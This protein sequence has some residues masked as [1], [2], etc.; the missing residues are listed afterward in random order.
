MADLPGRRSSSADLLHA[1]Y[2]SDSDYLRD[3][4]KRLDLILHIQVLRCAGQLPEHPLDPFRGIVLS[5]EAVLRLFLEPEPDLADPLEARTQSSKL[6]D[7]TEQLERLQPVIKQKRALS[8]L[9]D[10]PLA[11]PHI[12]ERFQ[13]TELEE[14]IVL[15]CL[16]P[17]L[18]VKYEK[19]YAYLQD[20]VTR[21]KPCAD[22]ILKLLDPSASDPVIARTIFHPHAGLMKHQLL[23][24]AESDASTNILTRSLHLDSQIIHFLLGHRD[25]DPRLEPAARFAKP[26]ADLVPLSDEQLTDRV[27]QLVATQLNANGM[28][29]QK[30]V[31]GLN[32][33]RGSGKQSLAEAVCRDLGIPL[34]VGDVQ[35]M[36]HHPLSFHDA[37]FLLCR[38]AY[39]HSAALCLYNMDSL[40]GQGDR[41]RLEIERFKQSSRS[42]PSLTFLLGAESRIPW[43]SDGEIS[44]IPVPFELPDLKA[45]HRLWKQLSERYCFEESID[46]EALAEKFRFTPGRIQDALRTARSYALW[47]NPE[48]W[49]IG[50][51]DLLQACHAQ[52]NHRLQLHADQLKPAGSWSDLILPADQIKRLKELIVQV[53]LR[54]IVHGEWGFGHKL[55]RGKGLNILLHGPPGTGKT[56]AAEVIAKELELDLYRIDLSQVVSKYIGETEKNLRQVFR[57]AQDSYAILLFDEADALFGKR[58]EVKDAHDRHAN[59]EIAYLLQQME[60]YDGVTILATNLYNN[61]DEAFIRRMQFSIE[62]PLPEQEYRMEIWKAMFPA[63]A[64]L[65]DDIDWEFLSRSFK[66][67][68]GHI[69]NAVLSAA[70]LA[71]ERSEAIGMKHLIRAVAREMD[72]TGKICSK[73]H[74]G[75]YYELLS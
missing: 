7:L 43:E 45:R 4:L 25:L 33:P 74:F 72:K 3:E 40:F 27:R 44:Y 57:E 21:H 56:T 62:F 30:L 29:M 66:I 39:L 69:K 14:Q 53:Q 5:E 32:G 60:E 34:I 65:A 20:D 64:P 12:A 9:Q 22:L 17:E 24:F 11:L 42:F 48:D 28:L 31:F 67:S 52:T 68:G 55:S 36:L 51:D 37:L 46:F 38:E 50:R 47:R 23:R 63:E 61:L 1:P 8:L 49:R 71:A 6:K 75:P 19:I 18:N 16:A 26:S 70:F 73:D 35:T 59:T 58:T 10:I 13:L 15:L 2:S 54:R 41:Y